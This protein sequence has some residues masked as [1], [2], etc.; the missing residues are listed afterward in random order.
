MNDEEF[1]EER[2]RASETPLL[3][4]GYIDEDAKK[5]MAIVN[6]Q[7]ILQ[8]EQGE[9]EVDKIIELLEANGW[10]ESVSEVLSR[11]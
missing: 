7:A 2:K 11:E 5:S 8:S 6:L 1:G 10:D 9:V 3:D 4:E